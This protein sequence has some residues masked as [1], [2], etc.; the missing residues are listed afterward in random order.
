MRRYALRERISGI[1]SR[2]SAEPRGPCRRRGGGQSAVRRSRAVR[3]VRAG[4]SLAR[5]ACG[6]RGLEESSIG[7]SAGGAQER[8]LVERV[9]RRMAERSRTSST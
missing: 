4:V 3:I 6:V 8:R 7:A 9:L 5:S 1:G 2:R